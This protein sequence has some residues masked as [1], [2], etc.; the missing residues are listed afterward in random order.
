MSILLGIL[1]LVFFVLA[2]IGWGHYFKTKEELK[3]SLMALETI[4]QLYMTTVFSVW[5]HIEYLE[6]EYPHIAEESTV[7]TMAVMTGW[8]SGEDG[9]SDENQV[10]SAEE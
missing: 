5:H 9:E 6:I 2:A 7:K 4:K 8:T 3:D 1:A 10:D